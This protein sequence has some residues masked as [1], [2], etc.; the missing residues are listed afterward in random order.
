MALS[1]HK[2]IQIHAMNTVMKD[3][4]AKITLAEAILNWAFKLEI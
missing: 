2:D 1:S 3:D 4:E